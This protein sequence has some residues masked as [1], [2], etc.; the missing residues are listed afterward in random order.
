[1]RK[2]PNERSPPFQSTRSFES[3]AHARNKGGGEKSQAINSRS[4][5]RVFLRDGYPMDTGT[6]E[7][8]DQKRVFNNCAIY[9]KEIVGTAV[10]G[11]RLRKKGCCVREGGEEGGG[12]REGGWFV[13]R[14]RV[15]SNSGIDFA[16]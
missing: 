13:P 12:G 16:M 8:R 3:D 15:A 9:R 7:G 2:I 1:M 5:H 10:V 4:F 6:E 14:R 11:A